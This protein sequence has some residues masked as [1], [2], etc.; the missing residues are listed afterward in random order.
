[1]RNLQEMLQVMFCKTSIIKL[2][3][4]NDCTPLEVL[5][6]QMKIILLLYNVFMKYVLN[7]HAEAIL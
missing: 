5:I 3:V 1:M 2:T 7:F 6:N 4:E